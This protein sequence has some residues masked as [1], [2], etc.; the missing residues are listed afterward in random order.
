VA[1]HALKVWR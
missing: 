1:L